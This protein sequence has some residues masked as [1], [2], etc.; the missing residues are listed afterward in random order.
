MPQ[1]PVPFYICV[2]SHRL[3][4]FPMSENRVSEEF[5]PAKSGYLSLRH[6]AVIYKYTQA[7]YI[8]DHSNTS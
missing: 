3:V 8:C 4:I 1:F 6:I 2:E 5:L 7:K